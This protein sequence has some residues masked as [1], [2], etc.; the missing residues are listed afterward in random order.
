LPVMLTTVSLIW[1]VRLLRDED[2]AAVAEYQ[3]S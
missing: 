2:V 3:A 1:V